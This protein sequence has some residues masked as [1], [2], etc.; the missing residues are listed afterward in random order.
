MLECFC[1]CNTSY[2]QDPLVPWCLM[3]AR[4]LAKSN[5][6][7]VIL[8]IRNSAVINAVRTSRAIFVADISFEGD[9][10]MARMVMETIIRDT[11]RNDYCIGFIKSNAGEFAYAAFCVYD[12]K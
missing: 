6:K 3:I 12:K 8:E 7:P 11:E 4:N 9:E 5:K 2:T 1:R 10:T